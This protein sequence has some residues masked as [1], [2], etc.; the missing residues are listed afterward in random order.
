MENINTNNKMEVISYVDSELQKLSCD[1][2]YNS[3][4]HLVIEELID[5]VGRNNTINKL[6]SLVKDGN[7]NKRFIISSNCANYSQ[8]NSEIAGIVYVL[9][10]DHNMKIYWDFEVVEENIRNRKL[11]KQ[12]L[13]EKREREPNTALGHILRAA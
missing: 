6:G 12:L 3:I 4:T 7:E 2:S 1:N 10:M 11:Q 13:N 8:V 9:R 5:C